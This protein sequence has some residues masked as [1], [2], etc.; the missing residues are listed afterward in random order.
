MTKTKEELLTKLEAGLAYYNLAASLQ[1]KD[2]ICEFLFTLEKWNKAY[3]LTAINQIQDMLT[4]HV[5]DSLGVAPF[6]SGENMLDVGTG[7]GLPG[8]PLSIIRPDL[9]FVL[10]DSCRKKTN[11]VQYVVTL[12]GLTNVTVVHSRVENYQPQNLFA[13][14]ISRAFTALDKFVLSSAHLCHEDGFFIA[15]KGKLTQAKA[16]PLPE[17]YILTKI[18][19]VTIPGLEGERCLVFVRK[20]RKNNE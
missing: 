7:A 13:I 8:I 1:Q 20:Q 17:G 10:L 14:I 9:N 11:F 12:L 16:E 4:K 3:N 5:L 18:E 6:I 15:M 19:T 2:K